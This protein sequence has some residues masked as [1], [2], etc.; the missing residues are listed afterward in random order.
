MFREYQVC[1]DILIC[2]VYIFVADFVVIDAKCANEAQNV[3]KDV[4]IN[5]S[6]NTD[7]HVQTPEVYYSI[8]FVNCKSFANSSSTSVMRGAFLCLGACVL[9][10]P[11]SDWCITSVMHTYCSNS[12]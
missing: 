12:P 11:F 7:I 5:T 6:F 4:P 1:H 8:H 9:L 3:N 2:G 10:L